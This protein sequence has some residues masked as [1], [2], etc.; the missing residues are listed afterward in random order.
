MPTPIFFVLGL[1][2][3]NVFMTIAWYAH[4]KELG[5]KPWFIA[6][7]ISWGIALMEYLFQVPANRAGYQT[8][9]LEQMKVIQEVISLAVFVPFAILYMKEK[10]SINYLLACICLL[11]AVFFI[12]RPKITL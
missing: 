1:I 7:L 11:G 9:S 5:G 4:L 12:M 3:S 6:A 10:I 8:F 2:L